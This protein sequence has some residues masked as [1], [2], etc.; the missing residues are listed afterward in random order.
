MEKI[1]LPG[2]KPVLEL[3][4]ESPDLIIKIWIKNSLAYNGINRIKEL[5]QHNDIDF[6][7]VPETFL[8]ELCKKEKFA[9]LNHQGIIAEIKYSNNLSHQALFS[10][11]I[12]SPLPIILA[13]DQIQDPGNLG[14]VARTAYALGA[15]GLLLPK[16]NSATPGPGALKTSAGAILRLPCSITA[17]LA[18]ALDNGE[19][20]GFQIYAAAHTP[21]AQNAFQFTWQFPC[22]IV[23]G[24]EAKGI[25]PNVLKRCHSVLSIPFRRK[26]D[27]LN[28]A[29][30]AAILLGLASRQYDD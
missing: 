12:N 2:L 30:A 10:K 11:G 17:N 9:R 15:A 24:N 8:D 28:I 16:H 23:L 4:N 6:A 5:C 3:L 19:E 21:Q 18:R 22:I 13:L 27:S 20:A 14:T 29:Q 25:R 26:F 7:Q 1:Y